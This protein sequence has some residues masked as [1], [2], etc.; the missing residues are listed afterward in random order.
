M[1]RIALVWQTGHCPPVID[2]QS[3]PYCTAWHIYSLKKAVLESNQAATYSLMAQAVLQTAGK[4]G[5]LYRPMCTQG[6]TKTRTA[7]CGDERWQAREN[8]SSEMIGSN[9]SPF[10]SGMRNR[11][12]AGAS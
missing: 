12:F 6:V 5:C 9:R 2:G 10:P 11:S 4:P 8:E 1:Q 7:Q 3:R